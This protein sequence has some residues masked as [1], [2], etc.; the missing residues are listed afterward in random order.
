M[1]LTA[2]NLYKLSFLITHKLLRLTPNTR[3]IV[4]NFMFFYLEVQ[5]CLFLTYSSNIFVRF[6]NTSFGRKEIA[7]EDKSLE[8]NENIS[9]ERMELSPI[10][11]EL[12]LYSVPFLF[13]ILQIPWPLKYNLFRKTY[14][15]IAIQPPHDD[16]YVV[17]AKIKLQI[18]FRK[19]DT[20]FFI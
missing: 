12:F 18:S 5:T 16:T 17:Y 13:I 1:N 8:E 19:K 20:F 10:L 14:N 7:F 6:R 2:T 9:Y 4:F 3:L 15:H 11:N